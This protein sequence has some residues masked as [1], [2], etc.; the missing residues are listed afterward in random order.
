MKV[1][2]TDYPWPDT[3][4]E[5]AICKAAG[6][7]LVAGP[8]AVSAAAEIEA[9][10]AEHQP[11]AIMC[12]WAPVSAKALQTP[13]DLRVV[14]RLG[15]GLDNIA[16][17]V[18]TARGA[19]VTNVPD[20]SVEEVSDH[21]IALLLA[22]WRGIVHFNAEVKSG[23][24]EPATAKL[25][26]TRDMTVGIVG[27][28]RIGSLTARKLATGFDTRVLV[29]SPSLMR[30]R[31]LGQEIAPGR[32]VATLDQIAEQADAIALHLPLT[33]ESKH[34][35]D[36]AFLRRCRRKPLLINVSRGA[37]VHNAA[38]IR[39]LDGGRLSGAALDVVDGEPTP[40]A[41]LVSR[42][43]VIMTPH[44]AFSSAASLAEL[45]TRCTD[46]VVRVLRGERPLHPCNSPATAR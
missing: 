13:N 45:R 26:R 10:V 22:H 29:T 27:Y 6:H 31:R 1:L 24:W 21:V 16:I 7:E 14:A 20:Y 36:D 28:G 11:Q 37:L 43:D 32:F 18:A 33:N 19:W 39:A 17:D 35:V 46:D 15:V 12:C 4:I 41:E 3:N 40:P 44:I 8:S 25:T 2:I 23:R 42:S 30:D 38:L 5:A 34:L 9:L